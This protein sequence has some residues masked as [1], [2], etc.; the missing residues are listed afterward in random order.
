MGCAPPEKRHKS[1]P[2]VNAVPGK[3]PI[4]SPRHSEQSKNSTQGNENN[5][6]QLPLPKLPSND[7][8]K[9]QRK[10]SKPERFNI[11]KRESLQSP[12]RFSYDH[13]DSPE[14]P[15]EKEIIR[16][17]SPRD[18]PKSPKKAEDENPSKLTSVHSL[19]IVS[20]IKTPKPSVQIS[21]AEKG[22]KMEEAMGKT[23]DERPPTRNS[24]V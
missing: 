1:I 22:K 4:L 5:L 10:Q 13:R 17:V 20:K 11:P 19:D 7:A 9:S 15:M 6:L 16:I 12:Q 2:A 21:K 8:L 3:S 24:K 14:K 18:K 23:M